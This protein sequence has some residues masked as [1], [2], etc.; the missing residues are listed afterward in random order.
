MKSNIKNICNAFVKAVYDKDTEIMRRV[1]A[2]TAMDFTDKEAVKQVREFV[3]NA[4]IEYDYSE[5]SANNYTTQALR[6]AQH[7][8]ENEVSLATALEYNLRGYYELELPK[9]KVS[10][11]DGDPVEKAVKLLAKA[12][13]LLKGKRSKEAS[14]LR[15]E[16]ESI[17][18]QYE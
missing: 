10:G 18:S 11:R 17:L 4:F 12:D 3:F 15:T 9:R 5:G 16:I 8:K 14:A 6:V 7:M 2:L 13:E 1:H